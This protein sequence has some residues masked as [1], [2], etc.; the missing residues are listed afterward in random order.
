MCVRVLLIETL[1]LLL[2]LGK[3]N[4]RHRWT[5][6]RRWRKA[7]SK[8]GR[9]WLIIKKKKT[10]DWLLDW[11]KSKSVV[12][13]QHAQLVYSSQ[14]VSFRCQVRLTMTKKKE[15]SSV[16]TFLP[17]VHRRRSFFFS[18]FSSYIPS[19]L[20]LDSTLS[21]S[22]FFFFFFFFF[23]GLLPVAASSLNDAF[24]SSF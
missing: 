7:I 14:C 18:S 15:E 20:F 4:L 24:S 21:N 17:S 2:F 13:D 11:T 9:V 23:W 19:H 3:P 8:T 1:L 12:D 16:S 5:R 22:D 10:A 6:R